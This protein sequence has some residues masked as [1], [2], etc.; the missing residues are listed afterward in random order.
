MICTILLV[1][2]TSVYGLDIR[3]IYKAEPL[4]FRLDSR[5][6]PKIL[7]EQY[8]KTSSNPLKYESVNEEYEDEDMI[9]S[10]KLLNPKNLFDFYEEYFRK[11]EYNPDDT[12]VF[13]LISRKGD[14][15]KAIKND[16]KR[17]NDSL[18]NLKRRY[19]AIETVLPT[20]VSLR[21][22]LGKNIE[23]DIDITNIE[24]L[25]K[26]YDF[27]KDKESILKDLGKGKISKKIKDNLD[28]YIIEIKNLQKEVTKSYN[29]LRENKE[30]IIKDNQRKGKYSIT[31]VDTIPNLNNIIVLELLYRQD[32]G[33]SQREF[34]NE[35][36]KF[37]NPEWGKAVKEYANKPFGKDYV[38]VYYPCEAEYYEF[39]DYPGYAFIEFDYLDN[40][41]G[42]ALAVFDPK[43]GNLVAIANYP[44]SAIDSQD[45]DIGGVIGNEILRIAYEE[46]EYDIQSA[47]KD[48][49]HYVKVQAGME[50]LTKAEEQQQDRAAQ[51]VADALLGGS[52]DNAIY[53]NTRKGRQQQQKHAKNFFMGL[54]S[55]ELKGTGEGSRWIEQVKKDY[56]EYFFNKGPLFVKRVS[57]TSIVALYTD[58]V[59]S[60]GFYLLFEF[61]NNGPFRIKRKVTAWLEYYE[62]EDSEE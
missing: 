15:F 29:Y 48:V 39:D 4:L 49:Q 1:I 47:S 31:L 43:N 14:D 11:A 25:L 61:E 38:S 46:D 33:V 6:N 34:W 52:R 59:L 27:G 9:E 35:A 30:A 58:D 3:K 26:R 55:A 21:E 51:M 18:Q 54:A 44:P 24:G 13:V 20:L 8:A 42:Q 40:I 2:A 23:S 41:P 32:V 28:L 62:T 22:R 17:L 57:P 12:L 36:S 56:N 45:F 16:S 60:C 50:K 5:E 53:G 37:Y 7:E 10:R 19:E